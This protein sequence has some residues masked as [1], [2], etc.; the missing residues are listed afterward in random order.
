MFEQKSSGHFKGNLRKKGKGKVTLGDCKPGSEA[1][2]KS[3]KALYIQVD[4][5][6]SHTFGYFAV[7]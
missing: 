2:C 1:D 7:T 3:T 4:N 6:Y 5:I